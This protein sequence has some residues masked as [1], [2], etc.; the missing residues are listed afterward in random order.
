M[1]FGG[2]MGELVAVIGCG[3]NHLFWRNEGLKAMPHVNIIC[4]HISH[5]TNNK[6]SKHKAATCYK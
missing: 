5:Q 4:L 1:A 6:H 3:T 2:R